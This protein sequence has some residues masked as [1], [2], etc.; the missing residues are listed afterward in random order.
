MKYSLKAIA[1]AAATLTA[2]IAVADYE[3]LT[4]IPTV[5]INTTNPNPKL[6]KENY[7][8]GTITVVSQNAAEAHDALPMGVRGRGNSTWNMPKKPYRV[9]LDK[10]NNFMGNVAKAKSWVFLANYADK[11]LMRNAVAFEIGRFVGLEYNPSVKFVDLVFNGQYLGN[12]MVTD[13]T[14][15]ATGRVPVEEQEVTDTEAPAINGGYLLE[16]DGFADGEPVWF[17]T[18]KG[19]KVTVKYP[20]DDEIN[21]AQLNYIT[22]FVKELE[23]RLFADNYKDPEEGYRSMVDEQS[24]INWYIACELTGNSDCFW[25]TYV[26]K[27]RDE[28]KLYF[29]PLWD[30]DIAFNNDNRLGDA[31][32][33]LMRD[34]AHNPRTWIQRMWTDPWFRKAVNERWAEL[35][36][37]GIQEHLLHYVSNTFED[38][39]ASANKNFTKW[40]ILNQRVYQETKLFPTYVQTVD[41]LKEY[42]SLR[43]EFLTDS[44]EGTD[45]SVTEVAIIDGGKYLIRHS[46]G[47]YIGDIT[48]SSDIARLSDE[49]G[50]A[51]FVF[52]EVPGMEGI[53]GLRYPD[54]RYLGSDQSYHTIFVSNFTNN[55]FAQ[56]SFEQASQ[57]PYVL[58][59]N[60][61]KNRYLGVDHTAATSRVYTDKAGNTDLHYWRLIARSTPT[62]IEDI[63]LDES[64][65]RI[66]DGVLSIEGTQINISLYKASGALLDTY[67]TPG[68]VILPY[69]KGVYIVAG[70]IDGKPVSLKFIR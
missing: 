68:I 54:G 63:E 34:H 69:E 62:E 50:A 4:N 39:E 23:R 8:E 30:Y 67:T 6:D 17:Q 66:C 41:Y 47:T 60:I 22:T 25:S 29:G 52:E 56:F 51:E 28:D 24:L 20:K 16:I 38:I 45:P 53:Y 10:K 59:K 3:Q 2:G 35:I 18:D 32:A 58:I 55:T 46:S 7:Q 5:Y 61:G 9:K 42:L 48:P 57:Q 70:Q 65:L 40:N 12:Y 26:Y 44:F 1:L 37:E 27:K 19:L 43:T 49:E 36:D 13:Q 14:E 31:V 33:K 21:P 64:P 11:S 15:V